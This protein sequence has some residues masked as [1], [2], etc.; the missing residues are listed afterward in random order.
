[1]SIF[2]DKYFFEML[3]LSPQKEKYFPKILKLINNGLFALVSS[4]QKHVAV[5]N[6]KLFA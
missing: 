5:S 4:F 2:P 1:M 3:F 6:L